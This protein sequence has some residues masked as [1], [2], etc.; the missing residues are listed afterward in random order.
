MFLSKA[1]ELVRNRGGNI[2]H[3][4]VT[5]ICNRPKISDIR[6]AMIQ[7]MAEIMTVSVAQI[8]VKGTTTD[9]LGFTGRGEGVAAQAVA[10][11][12]IADG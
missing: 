4:D 2:I 10:T 7:R 3:V 8:N 5:L 9:G 11:V 12:S 6:A 1:V